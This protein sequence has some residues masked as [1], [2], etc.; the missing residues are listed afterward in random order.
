MLLGAEQARMPLHA[1]TCPAFVMPNADGA[2]YYRFALDEAGWRALLANLPRLNQPEALTVADSLSAAYQANRLSTADFLAAVSSMAKSDFPQVALA[3]DGDLLRMRDYLAPAAAR[4]PL[5]AF[6]RAIYRP[7]LDALGPEAAPGGAAADAAAIERALFRANLVRLLALEAHDPELRAGLAEQARR[8][9]GLGAPGASPDAG[10]LA[11]A[12][13]DIGLQAGG[14]A[15]V[16][17]LIQRMLASNDIQFRN[18]AATALGATDDAQVGE[19]VRRLLLDP[20]LRTRE[21]TTIAFALAARPSQRRAT[22]D[23][24]KANHAAFIARIS[25]FGYRWL[26]RFGAGFCTLPEAEEVRAFFTPL[27]GRL[28]GAE[29]TLA[30]TLEGIELCAAL[31][32]AK[33]D[34]VAR[35]FP[36]R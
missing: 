17:V 3:S 20:Q 10:A 11:P 15:F 14:A 34:E 35:Y 7:R 24:F 28:G 23:W 5:N 33:G 12:L 32:E 25:H 13:V 6:M 19:R 2:G 4:E 9:I 1:G 22:F 36:G 31:A 16:E 18:Q 8:Y 29:R 30:E 27:L 26:P 21:P